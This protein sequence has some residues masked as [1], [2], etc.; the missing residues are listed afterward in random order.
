MAKR[1][2]I[3]EVEE[4]DQLPGF[5]HPRNT[6]ALIGQDAALG[7]PSM[8]TELG[9]GGAIAH[10]K[11]LIDNASAS[12]PECRGAEQLRHLVRLE[13]ERLVPVTMS[14]ALLAANPAGVAA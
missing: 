1:T 11:A 8:A 10:F 12:I 14:D 9:L 13:S 3:V 5:P 7:R 4:P 6:M 2:R